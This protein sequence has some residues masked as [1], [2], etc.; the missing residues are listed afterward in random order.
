MEEHTNH[1]ITSLEIVALR[2]SLIPY[3][4]QMKQKYEA[5]EDVSHDYPLLR[6]I[7][8]KLVK[9]DGLPHQQSHPF[10]EL[11]PPIRFFSGKHLGRTLRSSYQS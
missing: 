4:F 9:I 2:I 5:G 7:Y 1:L 11:G 8:D 6:S 10:H 3:E